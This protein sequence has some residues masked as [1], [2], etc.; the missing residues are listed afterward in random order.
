MATAEPTRAASCGVAVLQTSDGLDLIADRQTGS[1]VSSG[2]V[3][4]E[5]RPH[6]HYV[7]DVAQ[8]SALSAGP[9]SRGE[10]F[11]AS[12][13]VLLWNS[14]AEVAPTATTAAQRLPFPTDLVA[15][16]EGPFGTQYCTLQT[17]EQCRERLSRCFAIR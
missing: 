2:L 9:L 6:L 4:H 11:A 14:C 17:L 16:V 8:S 3:A 12:I 7:D 1:A 5:S 10:S 15:A 13:P